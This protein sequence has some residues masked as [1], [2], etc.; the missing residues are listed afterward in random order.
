MW[1]QTCSV[2]ELREP[3]PFFDF[4][5]SE[6][7]NR[8]LD[9]QVA[10]GGGKTR[11]VNLRYF[12]R[13][14]ETDVDD[15]Q[16]NPSCAAGG[17]DD[18]Q[19]ATFD[20]NTGLNS[21]IRKTVSVADFEKNCRDNADYLRSLIA[22]MVDAVIR[23]EATKRYAQAAAL[24]GDWDNK[25]GPITLADNTLEVRTTRS[26]AADEVEPFT[27]QKIRT[28]LRQTNYC[29]TVFSFSGT[30]LWEYVGQVM[31]GCCAN[32]GVDIGEIARTQGFA[33]DYDYRIADAFG[34]DNNAV[35]LQPG[36]L[37]LL[38]YSRNQ[39]YEGGMDNIIQRGTNY[40]HMTIFDPLTGIPLDLN[41]KDDCG[42]MNI[43]VT[44][45]TKL[46]A[47]P[48]LFKVGDSMEN[49]NFFNE[50]LVNNA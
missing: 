13:F 37:A 47:L 35:V 23:K 21:Q 29:S 45:T 14:L 43:V 2:A 28:A 31:A 36:S 19:I 3:M 9:Q 18:E 15:D 24:T 6:L 10:P 5:T 48:S 12:Q 39:T 27:L 1:F 44:A 25:V 11:T 50:I 46:V 32:Q 26:G 38:T 17:N 42:T 16:A 40:L 22:R 41:I 34:N 33:I 4:I 7:N 20:I 49:V 8:G 30:A